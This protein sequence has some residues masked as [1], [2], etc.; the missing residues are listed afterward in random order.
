M[1]TQAL[2]ITFVGISGRVRNAKIFKNESTISE[3]VGRWAMA[4]FNDNMLALAQQGT[5]GGLRD[6]VMPLESTHSRTIEGE[7][8]L[9]LGQVFKKS[10]D[11]LHHPK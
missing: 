11:R 6:N 7:F 1:V 9:S 2:I 4:E 8:R 3:V 5:L 10:G